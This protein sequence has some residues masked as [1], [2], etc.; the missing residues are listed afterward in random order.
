MRKQ[1][2]KYV[3]PMLRVVSLTTVDFIASSP[4]FEWKTEDGSVGYGGESGGGMEGDVK[5][6][7]CWSSTSIW[8]DMW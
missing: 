2:R 5:G 7:I 3:C 1:K 8:D 4:D 6:E